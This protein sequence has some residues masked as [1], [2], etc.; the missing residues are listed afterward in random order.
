MHK[1]SVQECETELFY[2]LKQEG[3]CPKEGKYVCLS[4]YSEE[5]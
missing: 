1:N 3:N 2:G 4:R 5:S